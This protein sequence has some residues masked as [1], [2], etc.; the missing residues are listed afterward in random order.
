MKTQKREELGL[1]E[2][3]FTQFKVCWIELGLKI[4]LNCYYS[5]RILFMEKMHW[6]QMDAP[7]PQRCFRHRIHFPLDDFLTLTLKRSFSELAVGS[8]NENDLRKVGFLSLISESDRILTGPTLLRTF[9]ISLSSSSKKMI[10]SESISG[11]MMSIA[12]WPSDSIRFSFFKWRRVSLRSTE[13]LTSSSSYS[14]VSALLMSSTST[15]SSS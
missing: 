2:K 13:S 1:I 8:V 6:G 11:T 7:S 15:I 10:S 5:D 9:F 4:I 14:L 3:G 12:A